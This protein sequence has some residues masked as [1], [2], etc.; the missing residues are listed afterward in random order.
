MAQNLRKQ[1]VQQTAIIVQEYTQ[2]GNLLR[3]LSNSNAE[4]DAFLAHLDSTLAYCQAKFA[5][6]KTIN[7]AECRQRQ[8]PLL[9]LNS[10]EQRFN[11]LEQGFFMLYPNPET[12]SSLQKLFAATQEAYQQL[13][14]VLVKKA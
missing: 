13:T 10:V 2:I 6:A 3:H 7:L 1:V 4:L 5:D 11:D 14:S 9:P 12:S 8:E